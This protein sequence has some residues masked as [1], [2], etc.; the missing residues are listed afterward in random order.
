MRNQVKKCTNVKWKLLSYLVEIKLIENRS[1]IH[2]HVT[3][4]TLQTNT[5]IALEESPFHNLTWIEFPSWFQSYGRNFFDR[6]KCVYYQKY[7]TYTSVACC[8]QLECILCASRLNLAVQSVDA[9]TQRRSTRRH[10]CLLWRVS[11]Q[12]KRTLVCI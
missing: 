5:E 6:G 4:A 2:I 3:M 10:T 1:T 12:F 9:M 8:M 7:S 11:I